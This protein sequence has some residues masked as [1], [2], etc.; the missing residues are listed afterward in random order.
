MLN[1]Q[2]SEENSEYCKAL[3]SD[4]FNSCY[5][6]QPEIDQAQLQI[7]LS[8][9]VIHSNYGTVKKFQV[10]LGDLRKLEKLWRDHF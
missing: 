6:T 2:A 8:R 4:F 7:V 10:E 9:S 1:G 3:V 5:D